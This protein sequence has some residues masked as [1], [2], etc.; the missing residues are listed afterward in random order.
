[1]A[2]QVHQW[3]DTNRCICTYVWISG[4]RRTVPLLVRMVW[5]T[6][7]KPAVFK[8]NDAHSAVPYYPAQKVRTP[9]MTA[10]LNATSQETMK[11]RTRFIWMAS[12]TVVTIYAL[13]LVGGVV[14][15]TGAGMGCPD[16]PKCFN[17]WIP[18]TAESQLPADYQTIYADRGYA[19]TTFNVRKTWTEYLN[20]LLGVFTGFTILLTLIFST[21]FRRNN[22]MVFWLSLA[23]FI[24]VGVQGWLG[25]RV[26]AS[27]LNPGMIT[28]HMLLAQVIVGLLIWS[29]LKAMLSSPL[30]GSGTQTRLPK[31]VLNLP[32]WVFPVLV[33]ATLAGLA[34]LVIGTQVREGVDLIAKQSN[35]ENRHLWIDNLPLVFSFHKWLALPLTVFNG[36]LIYELLGRTQPGL[37]RS[38]TLGLAFV[39]GA[40]VV[41]GLSMD[42]LHLPMFAQPLH[43]WF[44]SLIFGIQWAMILLLFPARSHR[45]T[46]APLVNSSAA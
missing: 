26:V 10:T 6:N 12:V 22:P 16:W 23:G 2:Q 14:R 34:Q 33:L 45:V 28:I 43:L 3:Q 5:V 19:E 46:Q 44:S 9:I 18:P 24:L 8:V 36:W 11:Q 17:Q 15:A 27:N 13:I 40:T 30:S 4:N 39:F 25:S 38:L 41:M 42:R 21:P 7:R 37:L 32:K 29:L 31:D 1:M 35:N 20:R